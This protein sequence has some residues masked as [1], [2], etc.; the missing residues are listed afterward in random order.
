[1]TI[2]IFFGSEVKFLFMNSCF[3]LKAITFLF[4]IHVVFSFS[5][6]LG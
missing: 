1:M 2:D 6:I 5:Q 4:S 3:L